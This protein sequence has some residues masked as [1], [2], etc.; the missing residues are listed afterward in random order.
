MTYKDIINRFRTVT[1]SH[2]MLKDFGYGQLS[3]LKTQSQLGPEEQGVDYPYLFLL[4]GTSNRQGPVMN[5]SFNMIVMDMAR[6]EEG[7]VFDN[8]ITIQS[9]CQQYIDDVLANLYYYYKD[10]PEINLTNISYTPF[11]EKYQDELAG[12][13][14][15]ITISVPTPLNECIAP[16]ANQVFILD[17]NSIADYPIKPDISTDPI[18]WKDTVLDT[19]YGM[20]PLPLANYYT[21]PFTGRYTFVVTGVVRRIEDTDAWPDSLNMVG[22]NSFNYDPTQS[23]WPVDAVL[24]VDYPFECRWENIDL[25]ADVIIEFKC[26]NVPAIEDQGIILAGANLKGYAV[27]PV[28][29]PPPAPIP[30]GTLLFDYTKTNGSTLYP[31]FLNNFYYETLV[32]D[33]N[34]Y[35]QG[36]Y[37]DDT[38]PVGSYKVVIS[39]DITLP[40]GGSSL[41]PQPIVNKS[42]YVGGY[43]YEQISATTASGWPTS[44]IPGTYTYNAEYFFDIL[45][46][47][48]PTYVMISVLTGDTFDYSAGGT[49]KLYQA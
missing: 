41:P 21:I 12:M 34:N 37:I 5:Y 24:G 16:F 39:Q 11:K 8:Y 20:R 10:Q 43:P 14:A 27:A 38:L 29:D 23:N 19:Y 15:S 1:E 36:V 22:F 40:A 45:L 48:N 18:R 30:P 44:Y 13:T 7:D 42:E 6:G 9:Q 2:L 17:V 25:I 28:P 49:I 4:P 3:D 31:G 47:A 35:W 46:G 32:V 33:P 26:S